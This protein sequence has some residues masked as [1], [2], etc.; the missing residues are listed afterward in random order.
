MKEER[1]DGRGR[2]VGRETGMEGRTEATKEG[3]ERRN[4]SSKED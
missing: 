3:K 1:K 4:E 2:W